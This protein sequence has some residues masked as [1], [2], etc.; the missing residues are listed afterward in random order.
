MD[1]E[2][3]A[4][5]NDTPPASGIT[6]RDSFAGEPD[7]SRESGTNSNSNSN[8]SRDQETAG[9]DPSHTAVIAA[10]FAL[11]RGGDRDDTLL[12]V[13]NLIKL[14]HYGGEINKYAAK[15][16]MSA[17]ALQS[18]LSTLTRSGEWP[19]VEQ[20]ISKLVSVLIVFEDDWV[21]L[22]R[23]ALL[24]LSSLYTLRIK[25]AQQYQLQPNHPSGEPHS[26]YVSSNSSVRTPAQNISSRSRSRNTSISTTGTTIG[27]HGALNA[28]KPTL[29]DVNFILRSGR[30]ESNLE[31]TKRITRN[32]MQAPQCG[33]GSTTGSGNLPA[34]TTATATTATATVSAGA[35]AVGAGAVGVGVSAVAVPGEHEILIRGGDDEHWSLIDEN[36][37]SPDFTYEE[38]ED[39]KTLLSAAIAKLTL[40]LASEWGKLEAPISSAVEKVTL[41]LDRGHTGRPDRDLFGGSRV[42]GDDVMSIYGALGMSS[43]QNANAANRKNGGAGSATQRHSWGGAKK[44][45]LEDDK[46][47][48]ILLNMI[49]SLCE[50][51][52]EQEPNTN[53]ANSLAG[54]ALTKSSLGGIAASRHSQHN[55]SFSNMSVVSSNSS[56]V[57]SSLAG[58]DIIDSSVVSVQNSLN[59]VTTDGKQTATTSSKRVKVNSFRSKSHPS[60]ESGAQ[61]NA[62]TNAAAAAVGNVSGAIPPSNGTL[63][64]SGLPPLM[65]P[66]KVLADLQLSDDDDVD[67]TPA[68]H[69]AD[70]QVSGLIGDSSLLKVDSS[71]VLCS[72]AV[73]NLAAVPQ[74]RP[75]LV[76]YGALSMIK[77]W[78]QIGMEVLS[79]AKELCFDLLSEREA[80]EREEYGEEQA[81]AAD[82][83]RSPSTPQPRP[84][85]GRYVEFMESYGP[86]YELISNAAEALMY[87]SGGSDCR[88]VPL[89]ASGASADPSDRNQDYII[90]WIDAQILSEGLPAVVRQTQTFQYPLEYLS[91]ILMFL[92]LLYHRMRLIFNIAGGEDASNI[93]R[94]VYVPHGGERG[95]EDDPPIPLGAARG[96]GYA[97]GAD[98]LPDMQPP[99]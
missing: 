33:S 2:F 97:P 30:L 20:Q 24:I 78:L 7:P 66:T 62:L 48:Q 12:A 59:T 77:A 88:C 23:S 29:R 26:G 32:E 35:G 9:S 43:A 72:A 68:D 60:L 42:H 86:A 67:N 56:A 96:G 64:L 84:L 76:S 93:T 54:V 4:A 1:A 70:S 3:P 52:L 16:M 14:C 83:E 21:L 79:Q 5:A 63:T 92:L 74:C 80:A 40:V 18:L 36:D 44:N 91:V 82:G 47:L 89:N 22:Q 58:V 15:V 34:T 81:P 94:A 50:S 49:S 13:N 10:V 65:V 8:S 31:A 28:A 57:S 45:N 90:G 61:P 17:G 46:I 95:E 38:E 27:C 99:G 87:I 85:P 73:A 98:A 55:K 71:A 25:T 39:I 41:G 69:I 11:R 19:E 37:D 51:S 75:G 6:R 53:G